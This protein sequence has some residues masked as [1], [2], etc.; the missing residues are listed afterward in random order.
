MFYKNL[1]YVE[2]IIKLISNNRLQYLVYIGLSL[3]ALG[4]TGIL[5]FSNKLLFQRFLGRMNPLIAFLFASVLGFILLSWLLS[6][7]WFAIYEKDN[8]KGILCSSSLAALLG[9]I[10]IL[11]DTR[12]V[13]PADTNILF[14]E[15]LLFYPAI[16]FLAEILFHVLPLTALLVVL[17]AIVKNADFETIVWICIPL[18]SLLE[19]VYHAMN[20]ASSNQFPSWAVMYVGFHVF[21]I[22]FFQLL[23]FKKYDFTSMYSFRL[24]YYL[25]WHI[26]WGYTRLRLLF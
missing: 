5:Y 8:L 1:A 17:N 11:V 14:P 10:M 16:G 7:K 23:I 3:G 4:F 18:V 20:M 9:I 2:R 26:G 15:S 21:L 6:Q 22:N 19:P 24:V 25:F 13:F 12:I